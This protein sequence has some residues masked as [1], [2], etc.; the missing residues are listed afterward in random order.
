M[1]KPILKL[2]G[3]C[4]MKNIKT[5][6]EKVNKEKQS[7]QQIWA[8][9][10]QNFS[11]RALN[12]QQQNLNA[13]KV[14]QAV[15]LAHCPPESCHKGASASSPL[16]DTHS[17]WIGQ[18]ISPRTAQP[19]TACVP[20]PSPIPIPLCSHTSPLQ[21]HNALYPSCRRPLA[22]QFPLRGGPELC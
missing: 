5:K 2:S 1:N 20:N 7:S 21:S 14:N 6:Y 15:A 3:T 18:V 17:Q 12:A 10:A 22:L 4:E 16:P 13:P 11:L 9:S 19:Y 8:I